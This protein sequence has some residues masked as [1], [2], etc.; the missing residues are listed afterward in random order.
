MEDAVPGTSGVLELLVLGVED[1][2]PRVVVLAGI[3]EVQ[4]IE[5]IVPVLL[6]PGV[7]P[8]VVGDL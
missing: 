1:E 8:L 6:P 2:G 7:A 3:E 4:V 5:E